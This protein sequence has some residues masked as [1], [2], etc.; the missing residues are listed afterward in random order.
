[1]SLSHQAD[2]IGTH[3]VSLRNTVVPSV[4]SLQ[5]DSNSLNNAH[6]LD[7]GSLML[8]IQYKAEEHMIPLQPVLGM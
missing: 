3:P 7:S 4:L 8:P 2:I 6:T 1:M 5:V